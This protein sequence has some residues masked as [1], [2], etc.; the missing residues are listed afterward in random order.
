MNPQGNDVARGVLEFARGMPIENERALG[1]IMIQ[2]ANAFG[3]DRG[4]MDERI[5]WVEENQRAI[6]R[7]AEEPLADLWWAKEAEDP[8]QFLA[9]C[10]DYAGLMEHGWGYVS[11]LSLIHI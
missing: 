8:W 11:H 2:G 3:M 7:A 4:T 10:F 9:F 1:W 6:L 5:A